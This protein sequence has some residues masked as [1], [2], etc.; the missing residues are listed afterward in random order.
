MKK[1]FQ[2]ETFQ[3]NIEAVYTEEEWQR[4][5]SGGAKLRIKYGVDVTSPFLHLG[6]AVNLWK[7]REL[8]EMGHKVI[9]L[10][11]D[12][13]TTI[14]DPTGR[15]IIRPELSQKDIVR[16]AKEFIR[17][18]KTILLTKASVFEV[19]K[20]SQ[21]Y[22]KMGLKEFL[23]LLRMVTH[24]RLIER[25]MFQARIRNKR[26]IYTH[27]LVYPILQGYDSVMLKSD[28]TIIGSD[29]LFNEMM[30][31]FFQE[32]FGQPPQVIM[33]TRL[34]PGIDG[35]EKMS[36][37]LGNYIALDD[38][39]REKFGKTMS[40]PDKLIIP[41][42]EAHTTLA[43]AAI[44]KIQSCLA[45][46]KENP[47]DAKMF[48]AEKITE[49]YHG[50]RI[51]SQEREYFQKTFSEREINAKNLPAKKIPHRTYTLIDI[52]A[53]FGFSRTESRRLILGGAVE[54]DGVVCR[55]AQSAVTV[56]AGMVIK[57][58][59]KTITRIV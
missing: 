11:G 25:D 55:N 16:N 31:R 12:F 45:L 59:K 32:K 8:Q 42:F 57:I 52:V 44:Q 38:G 37:S 49:R 48:L 47:R 14:G 43:D 50:A 53:T 18:V 20:N 58:G 22:G 30:G 5:I 29:Q 21:W 33:T 36:K 9:F 41:Y 17:Q 2:S 51:A 1:L 4:K 28:A 35:K 10:I 27:E 6:H 56:A 26:E 7:M 39:P 40:I 34:T 13:T 23:G 3:R 54:I 46:K 24:S 15:S 19:R